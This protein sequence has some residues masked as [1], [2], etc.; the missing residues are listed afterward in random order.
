[1]RPATSIPG[2]NAASFGIAPVTA[3]DGGT[4][5]VRVTNTVG[6]ALSAAATL[7]VTPASGT[8]TVPTITT[9]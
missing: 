7:T 8:V 3:A 9:N 2:A 5:T 6:T 4:Y 1:M